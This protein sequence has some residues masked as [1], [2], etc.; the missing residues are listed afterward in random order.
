M[1]PFTPGMNP[2]FAE[3]KSVLPAKTHGLAVGLGSIFFGRT[4]RRRARSVTATPVNSMFAP[5][6]NP[7]TWMVARAGVLPNSNLFAYSLFMMPIGI[8]SVRY[9]LTKTI[10]RK[11]RPAAFK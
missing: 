8:L 3:Q 2:D 7:A 10:W 11:S 6:G 4:A 9:G 5:L 1:P